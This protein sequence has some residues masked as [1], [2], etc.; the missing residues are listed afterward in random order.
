MYLPEVK[1]VF[2]PMFLFQPYVS[3]TFVLNL[4]DALYQ[5]LACFLI[6]YMVN[7]EKERSN[8]LPLSDRSSFAYCN[9]VKVSLYSQE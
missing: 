2:S 8:H 9:N 4:V 6:C 5:S 3:S 1:D 7:C